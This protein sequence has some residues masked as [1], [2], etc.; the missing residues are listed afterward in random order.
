MVEIGNEV[1]RIRSSLTCLEIL[2]RHWNYG[3]IAV[4]FEG[5]G[6]RRGGVKLGRF[7]KID[8][9][10][11][12]THEALFTSAENVISEFSRKINEHLGN[13]EQ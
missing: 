2:M 12:G 13:L 6:S 5:F 10:F 4:D 11:I 3:G 9:E 8:V 1:S 7:G